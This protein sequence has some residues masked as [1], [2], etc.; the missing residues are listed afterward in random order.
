MPNHPLGEIA[1]IDDAN[2]AVR[3]SWREHIAAR[4]D[5]PDPIK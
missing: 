2:A 3:P 5:T 1:D 4:S